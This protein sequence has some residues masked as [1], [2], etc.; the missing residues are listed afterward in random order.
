VDQRASQ[1]DPAHYG[2][3]SDF[4]YVQVKNRGRAFYDMICIFIHFFIYLSSARRGLTST[5]FAVRVNAHQT[6][7]GG[8]Q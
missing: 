6:K 8:M 4:Y 3:V 5:F 7:K 1:F 2:M